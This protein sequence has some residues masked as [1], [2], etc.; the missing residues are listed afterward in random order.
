MS[1]IGKKPVPV[2]D[3]AKV[4]IAGATVEVE[5]PRGKLVL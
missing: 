3:A 1:R 5:G 2:P 4:R